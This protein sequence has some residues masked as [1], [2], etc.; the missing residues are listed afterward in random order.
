MFYSRVPPERAP[1]PQGPDDPDLLGLALAV[2]LGIT[3]SSLSRG[4]DRAQRTALDPALE[5][6]HRPDGDARTDQSDAAG[7]GF[8]GGGAFLLAALLTLSSVGKRVRELG[9]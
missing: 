4:L 1:P 3:I 9:T 8:P 6:R 2:A 7:G 5:H